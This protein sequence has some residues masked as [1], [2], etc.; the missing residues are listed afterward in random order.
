M[1]L[2]P[3]LCCLGSSWEQNSANV[4]MGEE[5]GWNKVLHHHNCFCRNGLAIAHGTV[6]TDHILSLVS[7]LWEVMC[8]SLS[9]W[10]NRSFQ[11]CPKSPYPSLGCLYL[12]G[13]NLISSFPLLNFTSSK[14]SLWLFKNKLPGWLFLIS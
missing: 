5:G 2:F 12:H 4:L 3:Q 8:I 1:L 14:Q 6:H 7:E 13:C 11:H 10:Q 9:L